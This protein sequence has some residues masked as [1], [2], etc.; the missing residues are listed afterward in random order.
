[1]K[2][3]DTPITQ[4]KDQSNQ[5]EGQEFATLQAKV[6]ELEAALEES[7]DT[8]ARALAD[9]Q[10]VVRR[11][12]EEKAR[13]LKLAARDVVLSI[14]LPL[15]HLNLA[16]EQLKDQGITMIYQ[17]F[18]QALQGQGVQEIE[19]LG[20][21]FDEQKMEVVDKRPVSDRLQHNVVVGVIQRGYTMHGEVI[22]HAKVVIG[23]MTNEQKDHDAAQK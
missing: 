7:R 10:N 14:L 12:L 11:S 8:Q 20:H 13:L 9:Y 15:D 2:K 6:A 5:E 23:E 3:N 19:A 17:Q 21:P 22:R 18:Q 4:V 16:K 1:M